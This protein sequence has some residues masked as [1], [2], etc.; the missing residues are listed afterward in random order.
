MRAKLFGEVLQQSVVHV[1]WVEWIV[2]FFF[3]KEGAAIRVPFCPRG[4]GIVKREMIWE[5]LRGGGGGG[6]PL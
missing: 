1:T 4:R 3:F 6:V 2:V 5:F